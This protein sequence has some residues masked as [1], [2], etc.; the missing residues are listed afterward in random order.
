[1]TAEMQ[2]RSIVRTQIDI[3]SIVQ[4]DTELFD[5]TKIDVDDAVRFYGL[6]MGS[7]TGKNAYGGDVSETVIIAAAINDLTSGYK[8]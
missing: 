8:K 3:S 5:M 6:G 2:L 1:M 4:V 7:S